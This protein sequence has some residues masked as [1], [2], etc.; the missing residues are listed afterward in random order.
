[1]PSLLFESDKSQHSHP[2]CLL[3]PFISSKASGRLFVVGGRREAL[4]HYQEKQACHKGSHTHMPSSYVHNTPKIQYTG[5][6][7]Q[8]REALVS[9][10]C[11]KTSDPPFL[12]LDPWPQGWRTTLKLPA[13]NQTVLMNYYYLFKLKTLAFYAL[14]NS[15]KITWYLLTVAVSPFWL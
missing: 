10:F 8:T 11:S 13:P 7:L 3:P 15:S 4:H 12:L 2:A 6:M 1:M 14:D 9:F 5:H